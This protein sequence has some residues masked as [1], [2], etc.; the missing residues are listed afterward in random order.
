MYIAPIILIILVLLFVPQLLIVAIGLALISG[1]I[2]LLTAYPEQFL[3]LVILF[4]ILASITHSAYAIYN[5]YTRQV[6]YIKRYISVFISHIHILSIIGSTIIIFAISSSLD[7][8]VSP[9]PALALFIT[10]YVLSCL[11][12]YNNPF[13]DIERALEGDV[14]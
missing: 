1:L 3:S 12:V 5:R 9:G 11:F 8:D 13:D 6:L 4:V 14:N 10:A 2:F 7:E